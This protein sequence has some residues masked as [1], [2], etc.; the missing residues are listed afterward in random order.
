[1]KNGE[2]T[3]SR[4]LREGSIPDP[5]IPEDVPQDIDTEGSTSFL[6]EIISHPKGSPPFISMRVEKALNVRLEMP[7]ITSNNNLDLEWQSR[8]VRKKLSTSLMCHNLPLQPID[9][10]K[11]QAIEMPASLKAFWRTLENPAYIISLDTK[12]CSSLHDG[13]ELKDIEAALCSSDGDDLA[14]RLLEDQNNLLLSFKV[15]SV[16]LIF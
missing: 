11:D 3:T 6:S 8:E 13:H 14:N 16:S 5:R 2:F 7:I 12:A 10:Q 15:L 1:L 9:V 4:H